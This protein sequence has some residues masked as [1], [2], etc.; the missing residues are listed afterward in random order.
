MFISSERAAALAEGRR[1]FLSVYEGRCVL[2]MPFCDTARY[3]STHYVPEL[4]R[5][6]MCSG[7][8]CKFHFYP[9]VAK[10]HIAAWVHR[11]ASPFA[12]ITEG[13]LPEKFV[14]SNETWAAKIVEITEACFPA[15]RAFKTEP[16][17]SCA[18]IGREPGRKN[19][20]VHFKGLS[21]T[22]LEGFPSEA[23]APETVIPAV[24]RGT[25]Y[26]NARVGLD[27]SDEGRIEHKD[28]YQS[29][30]GRNSDDDDGAAAA[31]A[32]PAPSPRIG[33]GEKRGKAGAA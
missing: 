21:G 15:W 14:F 13:T 10:L 32:A 4:K 11:H 30:L 6:I 24:I 20:K 26:P 22:F 1:K 9:E 19:G 25:Y 17:G 18:L 28:G 27:K 8:S 3:C 12:V 16:Y 23:L 2:F 31:A 7:D 33:P 5:S 29:D